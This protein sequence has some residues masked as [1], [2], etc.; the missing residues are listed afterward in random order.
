MPDDTPSSLPSITKKLDENGENEVAP[1]S[2]EPFRIKTVEPIKLTTRHERARILEKAGLNL[3]KIDAQDV[4]IDLLTDSGTGALSSAQWAAMMSADESYAGSTSYFHFEA[5]VKDIF[6]MPEVIPTHQGRAAEH[7]LF[8]VLLLNG[9]HPPDGKHFLVPNNTHFDTT[10]AN[11]EERHAKAVDLPCP[12]SND[13][14]SDFPFKGNMDIDGLEELLTTKAD[15]VPFVMLTIT[16]NA[17]GAQPVS[18]ANVRA[19]RSLCDRFHKPLYIDA[20]RFAENAWLIQQRSG[21]KRSVREIARE[22]FEQADGCTMSAK[23]DGMSNMGGFLALRDAILAQQCRTLLVVT[24]GFPTY[25]GM[26]GR[27]M[28]CVAQG[29]YE[30]LDEHYLAY[31]T[32]TIQSIVDRLRGLGVPVLYPSGGHAIFLDAAAFF[33]HLPWWEFPGQ[34]LA[35]E[36]YEEGGL[37]SCEIGSVMLPPPARHELV[38]LAVP[39]RTYTQSHMEYVVETVW[40][41]WCRREHVR[42]VVITQAPAVLRHFS[43]CFERTNH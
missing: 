25:G 32:G 22:I 21:E 29:L 19:V 3:F 10:R 1:I 20:C 14:T 35:V 33:P 5:S 11:I 41:V 23:K 30:A 38:R 2:F 24:E 6:G 27:D 7:L 28:D 43:A 9:H 17:E 15:Q 16:N 8:K 31:R 12:E 36:L 42:G 34:A 26:S 39:R 4:M 40:K 18:L 13:T 37:R